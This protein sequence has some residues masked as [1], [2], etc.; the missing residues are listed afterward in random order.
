M[1][2]IKKIF[3]GIGALWS[4]I[5]AKVYANS[6]G[7]IYKVVDEI[8]TE[9]VYGIPQPEPKQN[10]SNIIMLAII[11]IIVGLNVILRKKFKEKKNLLNI[12]LIISSVVVTV[13]IIF[14]IASLLG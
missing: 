11:A 6:I 3:L 9:P 14:L 8:L 2:K 5:I 10:E 1:K 4:T 7:N 13:L 12:V